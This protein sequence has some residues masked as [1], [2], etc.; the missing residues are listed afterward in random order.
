MEYIIIIHLISWI[1]SLGS[2]T[3]TYNVTY[4]LQTK[5][6]GIYVY[7]AP[8]VVGC[9]VAVMKRPPFFT[10][11]LSKCPLCDIFPTCYMRSLFL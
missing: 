5:R 8:G 10:W 6:P 1:H 11:I 4:L 7:P 9:N 3:T 2:E